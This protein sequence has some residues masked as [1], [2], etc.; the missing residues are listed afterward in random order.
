M[1]RQLKESVKDSEDLAQMLKDNGERHQNYK[2][3]TSMERALS[4]LITGH[5]FL[6]NGE[7]WNDSN[8]REQLKK[9][10]LYSTCMSW[11]TKEN[12]AMWMLYGR[13]TGALLN[14]YPSVLKEILAC[15]KVS[16][17]Y[18]AET[19][20]FVKQETLFKASGDYEMF[21]SDVIYFDECEGNKVRLSVG[22]DHVTAEKSLLWNKDIVSKNYAWSYERECR[23]SLRLSDACKIRIN[24][25]SLKA[26]CIDVS[27]PALRK[28]RIDRLIR[29][30]I[31]SGGA[32]A[33]LESDLSGSVKWSI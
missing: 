17:G 25:E 31:Y 12:V 24:M 15:E 1:K 30:P 2:I 16:L 13:S 10:E 21:L 29:S 7:K 9:K 28:M 5:F 27:E 14:F 32:E 20:I 23:L 3:Y 6:T 18:F 22:E 26:V 19:G 8:D 33:G 4:F 11:S